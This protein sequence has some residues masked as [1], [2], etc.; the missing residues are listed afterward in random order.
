MFATSS[1]TSQANANATTRVLQIYIEDI[2]T[3]EKASRGKEEKKTRSRNNYLLSTYAK[4][5]DGRVHAV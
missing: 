4:E 3:L 1:R 2:V 5:F